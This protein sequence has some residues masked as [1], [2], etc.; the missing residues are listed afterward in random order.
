MEMI[1]LGGSSEVQQVVIQDTSVTGGFKVRFNNLAWSS[2]LAF[3][4]TADDVAAVLNAPTYIGAGSVMVSG[5]TNKL[6]LP[7]GYIYRI[8]FVG[9]GVTGNVPLINVQQGDAGCANVVSNTNVAAVGVVDGGTPTREFA[10]TSVYEGEDANTPRVAYSVSQQFSVMSEQFE[11]QQITILNPGNSIAAGATYKVTVMQTSTT[12]IPWNADEST[13]QNALLT[14]LK[15][16]LPFKNV[17]DGDVVVTRRTD[18]NLAPDGFI[19]MIY[20]VGISDPGNLADIQVAAATAPD[21]G[22]NN[23]KQ[24]TIRDGIDGVVAMSPNSIPLAS[25][26]DSTIPSQFLSSTT[27]N[28]QLDVYKVNGF[29]WTIKFKSS[30]GNIPQLGKQTTALSGGALAI[31]DDFVPGSAATSYV[32]PNLIPGIMYFVHVAALTD[33]GIGTFTSPAS[34][35]PSGAASAVRNIAAGYA[36]YE[37]E[38]QQVRLAASHVTEIQEITTKAASIAEVQ[39]LQTYASPASCPSGACISGSLAF[40]VPTV[41]TIRIWARA[42]ITGTFTLQFTR[43]VANSGS[44]RPIGDVTAAIAWNAD[45]NAVKSALISTSSGRVAAVT[46]DDIIVTRDGDASADFDYGYIFQ[47]TFVGTNVAGETSKITCSDTFVVSGN[48]AG[49]CTVTMDT[50]IAMGTDTAIQQVIVASK[51]T[52]AVGSYSLKFVHMGGLQTS[53]CI[54]FD[55]SASTMRATLE[56]MPNI[57]KAF[58]TREQYAA[59][60]FS[61]FVYRIFF[62]GSG[63]YGDVN[64]LTYTFNLCTAFQTQV[65]NILTAVSAPDIKLEV[66]IVDPGGFNGGNKFVKAATASAAELASDLKQLPVFG[67]VLVSQ[68]L[69]D[70][71]GGYIWTVVFN[72]SE[73][74]LPQFICAVDSFPTGNG[75]VTDT[76]TDGN[77]LSGSFIIEASAPIP[78]NA[79]AATMTAALEAMSWVG[80]VQVQRS[81][82][83][84]QY[85]YTWT[86]TFL[87]YRGDVPTLLVTSSLVGTGS[88]ITVQEVRKGNALGG[89]FTLAY[90]SSVTSPIKWDAPATATDSNSDGSSVQEKLEALDVIGQVS[91]QRSAIPDQEGGYIWLVTFLDNILNPGDLPLLQGNASTLSGVGALVFTKEIIKGSNAVG[92]QLWLSFDPPATDNGSP[93]TQYQV[94]WDTSAMF[95]SNP[96]DVFLSDPELLY[97][98][99]H[100][101]TSAPSLAW[102]NVKRTCVPAVQKLTISTTGSFS[103]R[104]RG[105]STTALGLTVGTSRLAQLKAALQ[106]LAS[107]GKVDITSTADVLTVSAEFLITFA[108]LPGVLPLLTVIPTGVATVVGVQEGITNFRKEVVVFSCQATVGNVAFTYSGVTKEIA[109]D[110]VLSDVEVLLSAVLFGVEAESISVTSNGGQ[111]LLC[112]TSSAKDITIVFNRV[113]GYIQLGVAQGTSIAS[114]ATITRNTAASIDGVYYDNPALVMSGTFQVGYQVMGFQAIPFALEGI[115]TRFALIWIHLD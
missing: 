27:A 33:V 64:P 47:I 5:D 82:P 72:D 7:N 26:G 61:G 98:T 41:Q 94:R 101:T 46:T 102:S 104:F 51:K 12:P 66:S 74:N 112:A 96:A 25:P 43:G 77:V 30:L 37:R 68:S 85:G 2:C 83:S 36:L 22:P 70:E 62:H 40:R 110:A 44:F 111:T 13:L 19:Y 48:A 11:I 31:V 54:P 10:L 15:A 114:D 99:Q 93:I 88:Q 67:D 50:D 14:A 90:R 109:F 76:L 16:D 107:I 73:G 59:D 95:K 97:R 29:L 103:L 86:I 58:V 69:P 106:A 92:D 20:F 53:N 49:D 23:V 21:I 63:V 55:A 89:T 45:A 56:L 17:K 32:I 60:G 81:A 6:E 1:Q 38:V 75:C 4:A 108:A 18:S 113:Y 57:D 34:I 52:L 105:E 78:F 42:A 65:S 28:T 115:G 24:V 79:D 87:D 84:P 8:T 100:I 71:Q 80:T 35:T 9:E 39:T 3:T 91:V